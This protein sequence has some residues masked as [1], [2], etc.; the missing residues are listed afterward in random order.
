[1]LVD[2]A[3]ASHNT[4]DKVSRSSASDG[5]A[6]KTR[7]GK[8]EKSG[9]KSDSVEKAYKGNVAIKIS[10]EAEV[11]AREADIDRANFYTSLGALLAAP[12]TYEHCEALR[13]LPDITEPETSMEIAWSLLRKAAGEHSVEAIDDEYHRLFI[14]LGRGE[15]VPYGSWHLTGFL[16]EKP[17]SALRVDLRKLGFERNADVKES[18]D[19]IASL[20]QAMAAVIMADEIDFETQLAFFN[21]HIG[22]WAEDF[23]KEL[24]NATSAEFYRAVGLLGESFI[25][26]EKQ[27]LSMAV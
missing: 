1:M 13:N 27:Y 18:E 17:L 2:V 16:M 26:V 8:S 5:T 10:T 20:C 24:Q 14:G 9:A 21:T 7:D 22:G 23:F 25:G 3:N 12:A 4:S 6:T 11:S 19:H 15:V